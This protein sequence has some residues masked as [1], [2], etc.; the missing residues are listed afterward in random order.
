MTRAGHRAR[1]RRARSAAAPAR[2]SGTQPGARAGGWCMPGP[3][4]TRAPSPSP[5]P[6]SVFVSLKRRLKSFSTGAKARVV[7][8]FSAGFEAHEV[9]QNGRIR[10]AGRPAPERHV[11]TKLADVV[12][13]VERGLRRDPFDERRIEPAHLVRRQTAFA[14]RSRPAKSRAACA[15]RG[16]PPAASTRSGS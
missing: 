14:R 1:A 8:P 2:C 10:R 12:R 7:P 13:K 11:G 16:S 3:S 4:H 6:S 15:S 9:V 5:T